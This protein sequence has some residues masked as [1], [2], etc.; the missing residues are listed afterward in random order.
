MTQT[1]NHGRR[2]E[3]PL[4]S[5]CAQKTVRLKSTHAPK[6]LLTL[7]DFLLCGTLPDSSVSSSK[8]FAEMFT[9]VTIIFADISGFTAWSSMR[10]PVKVFQILE[11]LYSAFDEAAKE[12]GVFKVETIGYCYV[13]VVGLPVP[14]AVHA[15]AKFRFA[16][17]VHKCIGTLTKA[18]EV[19]QGTGTSD[20]K[21]RIGTHSGPV[22][23]GVLR[24]EK[25][26]FHLFGNT[27]NTAARME[28]TGERG[29]MQVSE[30]TANLLLKFGKQHWLK[31]R[32]ERVYVKGKGE[33]QTYLINTAQRKNHMSTCQ[34]ITQK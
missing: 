18:L 34:V 2:D 28:S 10:K 15:V 19:Q 3:T 24:G 5:M 31:T 33:M 4:S 20:L 21:M 17:E 23:A 32:E 9:A 6:E 25:S 27:M 8:V 16:H 29:K 11:T 14:R 12:L 1:S 13:A 26:R 22:T 30:D 7:K